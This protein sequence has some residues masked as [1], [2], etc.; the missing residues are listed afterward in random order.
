MTY[1]GPSFF[2]S[3]IISKFLGELKKWSLVG[4][5]GMRVKYL[6]FYEVFTKYAQRDF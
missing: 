3:A 6:R 1:G 2:V 4:L 5:C